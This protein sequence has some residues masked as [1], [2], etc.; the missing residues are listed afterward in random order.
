M[1]LFRAKEEIGPGMQRDRRVPC[2]GKEYLHHTAVRSLSILRVRE[3]EASG[4]TT[5]HCCGG[6]M[7][8]DARICWRGRYDIGS[9]MFGTLA[10]SE[11][12]VWPDIP[13]DFCLAS[14]F[15]TLLYDVATERS[16]GIHMCRVQIRKIDDGSG[17]ATCR[18]TCPPP[19]IAL[20]QT[21]RLQRQW[22]LRSSWCGPRLYTTTRWPSI[23]MR[24]CFRRN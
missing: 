22:N 24:R 13:I 23:Y 12:C 1:I 16:F 17:P 6:P 9:C 7:R 4:E 21:F 15:G 2:L 10:G 14:K 19:F 3:Q 8:H 11:E 5:P 18:G 20:A